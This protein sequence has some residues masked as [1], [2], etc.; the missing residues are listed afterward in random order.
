M[1]NREAIIALYSNLA[2]KRRGKVSMKQKEL[3]QVWYE[4]NASGKAA[5]D[6]LAANG[7]R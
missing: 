2:H 4:G 5:V 6:D 7:R 1:L 3:K